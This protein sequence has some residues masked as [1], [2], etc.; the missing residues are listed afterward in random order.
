MTHS[1]KNTMIM[2][3]SIILMLISNYVSSSPAMAMNSVPF[4]N[5]KVMDEAHNHHSQPTQMAEVP[6]PKRPHSQHTDCMSMNQG[7]TPHSMTNKAQTESTNSVHC[8]E[9]DNGMHTCCTTVCSSAS[10]PNHG[11]QL[12]S[13]ITPSLALHQSLKIGDTVTRLQS[14]LRPPTV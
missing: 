7:D 14:I 9:S 13:T 4:E 11:A 10:Y 5:A 3:F 6:T 8:G 1:L 12:L 2:M